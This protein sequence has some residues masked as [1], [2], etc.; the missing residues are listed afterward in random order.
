M[1]R[2]LCALLA[3]FAT[4]AAN[5]QLL[6]FKSGHLKGQYLLG[7]YPDDSLLRDFVG[8]P[9][10]DANAP[11]DNCE[12]ILNIIITIAATLPPN[13]HILKWVPSHLLEGKDHAKLTEYIEKEENT[14]TLEATKELT[15]SPKQPPP[16]PPYH[17]K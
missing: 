4:A 3:L 9:T 17:H 2:C 14:P 1:R 15:A 13:H 10:H 6:E 8:T 11:A 16:P 5:A 12:D 7:T